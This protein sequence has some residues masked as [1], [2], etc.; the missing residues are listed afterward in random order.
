MVSTQATGRRSNPAWDF[1]LGAA[2]PIATLGVLALLGFGWLAS[3]AH[4]ATLS[5]H[6]RVSPRKLSS[7]SP[8][9]ATLNLKTTVIESSGARPPALTRLRVDMDRDVSFS[10]TGL[11]VCKASKI[12]AK[13]PAEA[14]RACK[15][16]IVGHG[17]S[18]S[19]VAFPETNPFMIRGRITIFNGGTRHGRTTL[20]LHSF[21][22]SPV[23]T[24]SVTTA[25][26]RPAGNGRFGSR[27]I[28]SFPRIAGGNG[29]PISFKASIGKR[30]RL[31]GT[32]ASVFSARCSHRRLAFLATG[33]FAG[34][35][36][37]RAPATVSCRAR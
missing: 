7:D 13:D 35:P 18:S 20:L 6:P 10:T 5:F 17:R 23:P 24:T 11:P 16:A 34:G 29:S 9:P 28:F 21:L 25:S 14:K 31:K 26:V 1:A 27:A 30:Y 3:V 15:G 22:L 33:S 4:G 37:L 32:R 2:I 19:E 36:S 8:S 12:S